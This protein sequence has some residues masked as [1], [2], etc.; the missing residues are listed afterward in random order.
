MVEVKAYEGLI[1]NHVE[2]AD[3]LGVEIEGLGRRERE[4]KLL[5]AAWERWGD[6]MGAHINGQFGFALYDAEADE[7]FCA[8]DP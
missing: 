2:L 7:L 3:E 8:R 4:E 5:V 1:R 6:Q